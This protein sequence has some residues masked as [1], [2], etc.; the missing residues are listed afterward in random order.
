MEFFKIIDFQ[1]NTTPPNSTLKIVANHAHF[2]DF[3]KCHKSRT[4]YLKKKIWKNKLFSLVPLNIPR[5]LSI[6][7]ESLPWL[8]FEGV[9]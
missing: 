5:K 6:F 9:E 3:L 7:G 8:I 4:L 1:K 2:G